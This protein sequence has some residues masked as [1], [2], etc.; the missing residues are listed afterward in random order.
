MSETNIDQAK[1]R[2]LCAKLPLLLLMAV[3]GLLSWGCDV[4]NK[5]LLQNNSDRKLKVLLNLS[6]PDSSLAK[7]WLDRYVNANESGYIANHLDLEREPGLTVFIFDHSYYKSQWHEHPG[8]PDQYLDEDSI[9]QRYVYSRKE[10]D[11]LD[12]TLTFPRD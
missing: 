2:S 10:L 6:Y 5:L 12:W 8:T 7:S 11:S 9:L 1:P 3:M 4:E